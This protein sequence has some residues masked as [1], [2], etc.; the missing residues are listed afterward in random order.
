MAFLYVEKMGGQKLIKKWSK[1]GQK[2]NKNWKNWPPPKKSKKMGQKLKFYDTRRFPQ[3]AILSIFD[4]FLSIFPSFRIVSWKIANRGLKSLRK[5]HGGGP[6][7]IRK[8]LGHFSIR[9]DFLR[10]PF[11]RFFRFLGV[12]FIGFWGQKWSKNGQKMV[13]NWRFSLRKSIGPL[14]HFST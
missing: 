9:G 7:K 3:E 12:I 8:I 14:S 5:N 1:N 2:L 11:F 4:V 13:K 10:K 6:R